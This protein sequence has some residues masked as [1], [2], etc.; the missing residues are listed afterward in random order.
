MDAPLGAFTLS[1]DGRKLFG[2]C[3]SVGRGDLMRYDPKIQRFVTYPDP[4]G[5]SA[6]HVTFSRDG[7]QAAYV[8]YP[9]MNLWKMNADGSG[10]RML[11]DHAALPQ[12]SPDGRRV[13]FMS[14]SDDN[15]KP[16]KIRLVSGDG[17]AVQEPVGSPEWQGIPTWTVDGK[18][19]IFGENGDAFPIRASCAIHR[20]DFDTG[21][22][23]DIP[24]S[25]GLWTARA[26]P[27]GRY[28]SAVTRD[29]RKLVLYAERSAAWTDLAHFADSVIGDNP[30][31][32]MDGKF[33]YFD[34]PQSADPAIYRIG[35][36][37][38]RLE[39]VASLKGIQRAGGNMGTWI[40][41]TPDHLPLIVRAAG[42]DE[43]YAWDW[44]AP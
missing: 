7:K 36:S 31:W 1:Q 22:T 25:T 37:S 43:I 40:G 9:E 2:V 14:L 28:I 27:T 20:F 13:A 5:L 21:K 11:T 18:G 32:S 42:S 30:S 3:Q 15:R 35:I 10:R 38:R 8:T 24:G 4:A 44:I 16:T 6:G 39:R 29:N 34:A 17:G 23:S 12:W 26:C 33:L 41:L 19:L